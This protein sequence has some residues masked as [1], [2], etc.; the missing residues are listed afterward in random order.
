M[1]KTSK[2]ASEASSEDDV[3]DYEALIAKVSLEEALSGDDGNAW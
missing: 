3:V 1:K 2:T